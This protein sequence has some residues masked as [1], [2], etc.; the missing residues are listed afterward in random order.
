MH[1]TEMGNEKAQFGKDGITFHSNAAHLAELADDHQP[2]NAGHV[3][4]ENWMG[5]EVGEETKPRHPADQADS[6]HRES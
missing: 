1:L 5:K 2:C 3:T 6:A 4:D